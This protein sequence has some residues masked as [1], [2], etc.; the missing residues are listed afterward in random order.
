MVKIYSTTGCPWCKKTRDYF[1]SKNIDFVE[2][3]VGSNENGKEEIIHL[4]GQSGTPVI[5]I[6]GNI[7]V[8]FNKKAIDNIIYDYVSMM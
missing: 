7:V 8:G 5:N 6:D 1:K 3:N 2:V 4:S